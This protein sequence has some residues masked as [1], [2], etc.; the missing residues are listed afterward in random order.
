M[1]K[2]LSEKHLEY[3]YIYIMVFMGAS[4][5][6]Y[7]KERQSN[8]EKNFSRGTLR[9]NGNEPYGLRQGGDLR[10]REHKQQHGKHNKQRRK[11]KHINAD[12]NFVNDV[13]DYI[14]TRVCTDKLFRE[15]QHRKFRPREQRN[16]E[17]TGGER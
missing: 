12:V 6:K 13:Y 8:E 9:G 5:E 4:P 14:D 15:C 1:P 7:R 11:H 16:G 2:S 17:Q 10:A 3:I